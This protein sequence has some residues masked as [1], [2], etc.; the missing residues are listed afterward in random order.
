VVSHDQDVRSDLQSAATQ[1]L[2]LDRVRAGQGGGGFA[3]S[4]FSIAGQK[5][6]PIPQVQSDNNAVAVRI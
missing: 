4:A 3:F 1:E 5:N 6:P 2:A